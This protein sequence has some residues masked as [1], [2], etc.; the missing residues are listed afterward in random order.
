MPRL[1]PMQTAVNVQVAKPI[2]Q[3]ELADWYEKQGIKPDADGT[4]TAMPYGDGPVTRD[5]ILDQ[6]SQNAL[7]RDVPNLQTR[8]YTPKIM[9][10]VG[11]GPTIKQFLDDIKA[12]CESDKYDVFTS[13]KT[14]SYLLS[15]GIKPNFHLIVDPTEK[16]VKDLDYDDDSIPLVLGLQCHPALFEFAKKR[17][18]KVEKFLAASI[19]NDD[20][21]NDREAAKDACYPGDPNMLGIGGGSMCGTRMLY[22]ASA[23]GYRRIEYYGM[24]GSI[25]MKDNKVV[26]CYAYS[27]PRGENVLETTA[28][29]GRTFYTTVTLARQAEELAQ[30]MD[31]LPGMDVE[32]YGDS[33][34]SN[35]LA[36]YKEVNKGLPIRITPEY[37]AMQKKMHIDR[38]NYGDSAQQ[39]AARV[40]MAAAQLQRKFGMCSVLDYGSG[41][42]NL[43]KAIRHSFPDIDG[44]SYVEYD[45]G[46]E[47][48][49]AEPSPATLVFCGDVMEHIEPECVDAVLQHISDL[50]IKMAIFVISLH[51]AKKTLPDGRNAHISLQKENWWLSKLRRHFVITESH[52]YQFHLMAVCTRF[53]K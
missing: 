4:F 19:T 1:W 18:R 29:N 22:F 48:K 45:P 9:V 25:E 11:G 5:A 35:H 43:V 49:D 32:V 2:S 24:D 21:R 8:E 50:A 51:P 20:G 28:S 36:I 26:N 37:Q 38:P 13:N 46:M 14:C 53:P 10:Y 15:K 39:H 16:K 31:I 41:P 7:R 42:G 47:G 27:K 33:L 12:K 44:V 34:M 3:E 52:A 17:G 40:F 30:M 23:R 6:V